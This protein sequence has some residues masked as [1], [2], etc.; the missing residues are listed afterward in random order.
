M[1][2]QIGGLKVIDNLVNDFYAMLSTDP[3]AQECFATH[4]GHD[5][6]ES[7]EKLKAFLSG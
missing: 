6:R 3:L 4:S 7:S 5:I 2:E 1:Y